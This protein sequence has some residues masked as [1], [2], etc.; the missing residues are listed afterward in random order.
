MAGLGKEGH[1]YFGTPSQLLLLITLL[2]ATH[3]FCKCCGCGD[4]NDPVL[5]FSASNAN[6]CRATGR[7]L[8]PRGVRVKQVAD[9]KVDT[10]NA[11]SGDLKVA[12]KGP[13]K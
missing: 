9:F 10:R 13:S 2:K 1:I 5:W 4:F 11:G 7:G 6:G 8:Q 12:I 3:V